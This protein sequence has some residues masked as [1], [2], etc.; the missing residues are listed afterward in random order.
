MRWFVETTFKLQIFLSFLYIRTRRKTHKDNDTTQQGVYYV[1]R[2]LSVVGVCVCVHAEDSV[3]LFS[4]L[5]LSPSAH[6]L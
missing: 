2:L 5:T 4:T 6:P 3:D 1:G